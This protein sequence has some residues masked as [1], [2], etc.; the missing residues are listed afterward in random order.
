MKHETKFRLDEIWSE[1]A[2]IR[3]LGLAKYNV[4]KAMAATSVMNFITLGQS[5]G[6]RLANSPEGVPVDYHSQ[7][8]TEA[9]AKLQSLKESFQL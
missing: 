9:E 4:A 7:L 3:R 1:A 5:R 2:T 6:E 8:L